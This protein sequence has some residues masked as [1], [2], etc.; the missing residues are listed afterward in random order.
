MNINQLMKQA[1]AMQKK[2]QDAQA[3]IENLEI[4]GSSGGGMV[5][6]KINGKGKASALKIDPK[7][8]DPNDSE[9]LADLIIAA[10]NNAVDKKE[11]ESSKKMSEVSGGLNLPAGFKM[12]F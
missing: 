3:V 6:I 7:I 8:I 5:S 1:Q 4:E 9:M 11:E 10:I 12:P 2:L